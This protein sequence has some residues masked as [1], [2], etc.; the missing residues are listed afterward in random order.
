MPTRKC[1]LSSPCPV[2]KYHR[3]L[4]CKKTIAIVHRSMHLFHL[5]QCDC[6]SGYRMSVSGNICE[7]RRRRRLPPPLPHNNSILLD[8]DECNS[9]PQICEQKC[10]NVQGSYFVSGLTPLKHVPCF[11]SSAC[12][13]KA[14]DNMLINTPA[15]VTPTHLFALPLSLLLVARLR[16]R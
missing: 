14:T 2:P 13:R 9:T 3:I 5:P 10:V 16:S 6:S 12:A 4:R 8:V 15:K 1:G 11:S 7:G